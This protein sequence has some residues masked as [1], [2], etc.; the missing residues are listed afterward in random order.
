MINRLK[1]DPNDIVAATK[2][3]RTLARLIYGIDFR[4]IITDHFE[5]ELKNDNCEMIDALKVLETG[6]IFE[7][8]EWDNKLGEFK[9]RIHGKTVDEE[10]AAVVEIFILE[11]EN[12]IG[13]RLVTFWIKRRN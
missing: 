8:P 13:V 3:T 9:Y 12:N 7:P 5:K 10:E 11:D 1:R 2:L 4:L 6:N